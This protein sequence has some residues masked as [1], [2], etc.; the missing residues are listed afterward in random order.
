MRKFWD[1]IAL[2]LVAGLALGAMI[3]TPSCANTTTPPSGGP[4][5]TIPPVIVKVQ[6]LSGSTNVPRKGTKLKLTF[7]EYVVIK[8]NK[9]IYLSPPPEKKPNA[10][11]RE[12]S[13]IV[14][15][16]GLL[17][18]A[19]TYVLDLT[20]AIVDN[21]EGNPF[22]GYTLVF[23]TGE[24]IDSMV[25][26]GTVRD[27]QTLAPVEGA[28]VMLYK[29]HSDSAIFKKRPDAACKTDVWGYFCLR[30]IQDTLY[31]LYAIQDNGGNNVYDADADK[32]AFIDSLI[33]PA[34]IV[35]DSLPQLQKYDLKDTAACLARP[36]EHEL[37]LFK[38]TSSKQMIVNKERVGERTAY[39]TFM[40]PNA[41]IDSIWFKGIPSKKLIRQFNAKKD[42]LELWINDPKPQSDTLFLNVNYWKTDSTGVLAK[43]LETIKLV[44]PKALK[45]AARKS[46]KDIKKEDTTCVI[47]T[48]AKPE[49]I[50][51]N[52]FVMEFKYPLVE[53]GWDSLRLI[54]MNPKQQK[55]KMK[56]KLEKDSLN[57]RR[58]IVRPSG[59]LQEGYEYTLK[60]PHRKFRDI[61]GFYNDSLD[62][63]VSLPKDE[64][65]SS[66]T[67]KISGVHGKDYIVDLMDEK[68]A[69]IQRSFTIKK[70][71]SLLFPYLKAGNYAIRITEDANGNGMIDTGCLLEHRQPEKVR[72]YKLKDGN[73]LLK[74]D[75]KTDI[76]QDIDL[77]VIFDDKRN[78]EKKDTTAVAPAAVDSTAVGL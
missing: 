31:R 72:L 11:I 20:G 39:I 73:H 56:F 6:P 8:E 65:A 34:V 68:I 48:D 57:L 45:A 76:E 18:S 61:N 19:K 32:V 22:P 60:I 4:K 47:T 42:S 40:A 24:R 1:R 35:N 29:D 58:F 9:N 78:H 71:G 49:F 46:K 21:N 54:A 55:S 50:E 44:K 7:N 52:G 70:D 27:N 62:V 53:D 74:V 28:T 14:S 59:K 5:D 33:R 16:E 25:L 26:S 15:F 67:L 37:F 36:S 43:T 30:N 2:G 69:K 12:K 38:E 66:L 13:L 77:N 23:S 41:R 64:K 51:Q 63:K 17:D 3:F 10:K 75:E